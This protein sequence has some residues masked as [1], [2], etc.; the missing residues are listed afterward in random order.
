MRIMCLEWSDMSMSRLLFQLTSTVKIQL[1]IYNSCNMEQL[2][3]KIFSKYC[4]KL[5]D[6][7]EKYLA[8]IY[9]WNVIDDSCDME[10]SD[11]KIFEFQLCWISLKTCIQPTIIFQKITKQL[12]ISWIRRTIAITGNNLISKWLKYTNYHIF[13]S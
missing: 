8:T 4:G 11:F 9:F 6:L 13:I 2:N 3:F 7:L 5:S 12:F 1:S 10:L